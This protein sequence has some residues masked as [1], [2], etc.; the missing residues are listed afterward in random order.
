M[1][2]KRNNELRMS[3][4]I[5]EYDQFNYP[6]SEMYDLKSINIKLPGLSLLNPG[7]FPKNIKEWIWSYPGKNDEIDWYLLC[8]LK[9][10]NYALYVAWC[11]Y[12]G[13][14]CQGGMK[15]YIAKDLNNLINY[16]MSNN[17]YK[18]YIKKTIKYDKEYI[19]KKND[20]EFKNRYT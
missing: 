11:D 5:H 3:K 17:I 10:N 13:F 9:N 20:P 15:L 2:K 18:L 19:P 12:T 8:K 16:A 4:Y 1:I 14:D 6:F 7:N